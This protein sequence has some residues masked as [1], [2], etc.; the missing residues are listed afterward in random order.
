MTARTPARLAEAAAESIRSI[1]HALYAGLEYPGDAYSTVGCLSHL[2][3]MLPQALTMIRDAVRNLEDSGLLRSDRDTLPEDLGR[4]Y[5]GLE[6]AAL[7][8]QTLYESLGRA[9]A[10]L[11]HIG[12]RDGAE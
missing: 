3:S 10:G 5:E 11:G 1:N 9:H 8:A 2:A 6:Q 7:D 12:T 4:A